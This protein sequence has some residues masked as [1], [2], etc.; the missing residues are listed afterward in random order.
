M[1]GPLSQLARN[2]TDL[3][4]SDQTATYD[5]ASGMLNEL[6]PHAILFT[7]GDNDTFPL[8]CLQGVES[9]RTDVAVINLPLLNTTWFVEDLAERD[10]GLHF[11]HDIG[12]ISNMT[13]IP[14]DTAGLVKRIPVTQDA[15]FFALSPDDT[16][17]DSMPVATQTSMMDGYYLI[18][19]QLLADIIASNFNTR[20]IYFS[21]TVSSG[22]VAPYQGQLRHEGLCQRLLPVEAVDR[23]AMLRANLTKCYNYRSFADPAILSDDVALNFG[24][25]LVYS[26]LTAADADLQL[27]QADSCLVDIDRATRLLPPDRVQRPQQ[28][29]SI[30][31]HLK[32]SARKVLSAKSDSLGAAEM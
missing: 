9:V 32:E 17:P 20:P 1:A 27:G 18:G 24:L 30:E 15:A 16:I 3:D 26:W 25:Q 23:G 11:S 14:A 4:G 2:Y 28:L 5:I 29:Q 10:P 6:P 19:D 31:Q 13:M 8:W 21:V 12:V 7:N 22:Y